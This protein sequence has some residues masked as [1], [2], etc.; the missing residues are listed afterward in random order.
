MPMSSAS[1]DRRRFLGLA[2]AMGAALA[3]PVLH[4]EPDPY[5]RWRGSLIVNALGGIGNPN[6]EGSDENPSGL[7][8]SQR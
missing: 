8:E 5:R 4:A 2:A 7:G 3:A 6:A 1:L